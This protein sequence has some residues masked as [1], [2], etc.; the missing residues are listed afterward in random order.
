MQ[1]LHLRPLPC[2]GTLTHHQPKGGAVITLIEVIIVDALE[3]A[4]EDIKSR[5]RS[6]MQRLLRHTSIRWN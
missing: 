5:M 4:G 1:G 2:E 3:L 6:K